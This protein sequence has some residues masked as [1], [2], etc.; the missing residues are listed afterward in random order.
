MKILI[1]VICVFALVRT[2]TQLLYEKIQEALCKLQCTYKADSPCYAEED[3]RCRQKSNFIPVIIKYRRSELKLKCKSEDMIALEW[4][5]ELNPV[6]RSHQKAYYLHVKST[7]KEFYTDVI[8]CNHHSVQGLLSNTSYTIKLWIV[9]INYNIFV[10]EGLDVST[11]EM[12]HVPL[13]ISN[14]SV[15]LKPNGMKYEAYVNWV[16]ATDLSCFYE[17]VLFCTKTRNL[18]SVVPAAEIHDI[19]QPTELFNLHIDELHFGYN[20]DVSI[21][22]RGTFLENESEVKN[23]SVYIPTCV[24]TYK[25][26]TICEPDQPQNLT[27]VENPSFGV[28]EVGNNVYDIHLHWLKPCLIPDYYVAKLNI[29][30]STWTQNDPPKLII[31][32]DENSATFTRINLTSYYQVYLQA[33]SVGGKS[34]FTVANRF[35]ILP[36]YPPWKYDKTTGPK[37]LLIIIGILGLISLFGLLT[38][39]VRRKKI[40]QFSCKQEE[41]HERDSKLNQ[42]QSTT[43]NPIIDTTDEW[44]IPYESLSFQRVLGEGEFGTVWYALLNGG[45][46]ACKTLKEN[47]TVGEIRQL[48]Q[49]I[50][51]MKNVGSHPNIVSMIGCVTQNVTNGPILIVEYCS[52]GDLLT[53][54]RSVYAITSKILNEYY[55]DVNHEER[56]FIN[57]SYDLNTNKSQAELFLSHEDILSFGRQIALGMEYLSNQKVLHRDLAARNIL[58]CEKKRLKVSDFGLSR[59]VYMDSV[60][61]KTTVGRLPIRWM[62]LESLTHQIYTTQSDVWSFGVLLWEIVSFGGIPYP[63][64]ETCELLKFLKRGDRMTKPP[65]CSDNIYSIM[66]DCWKESPNDRPTFRSLKKSFDLLLTSE[67]DYLETSNS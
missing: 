19:V 52:M 23:I 29:L 37:T 63:G 21:L 34:P 59:D 61:C 35:Y 10:S 38:I 64:I 16:P 30:N 44:E 66:T 22:S 40:I 55:E 60:Y 15:D 11:N 48:Q 28:N 20:Y 18:F 1:S 12:N 5:N 49:E 26:L 51:I 36:K 14:I 7:E 6:N 62:A 45:A 47:S 50:E 17:I 57:K 13:P 41:K 8:F 39:P 53:Y 4:N 31:P 32:G 56:H 33:I 54:L 27:V 42:I 65:Y 3:C 58:M 24:E 67:T 2:E 9:D 43:R 25:N 46:V